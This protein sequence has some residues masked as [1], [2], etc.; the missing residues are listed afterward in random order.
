MPGKT[1]T[2]SE[3]Q[4]HAIARYDMTFKDL[5]GDLPVD[6][7]TF[8][9]SVYY[10]M[11]LDDLYHLLIHLR[12]QN[13][14]VIS[15]HDNWYIPI[16]NLKNFFML[17]P[18]DYERTDD[19]L[20]WFDADYPGLRVSDSSYFNDVWHELENACAFYDDSSHI[21]EYIQFDYWIPALEQYF[22]NKGKP[23]TDWDFPEEDKVSFIRQFSGSFLEEATDEALKLGR[24]FTDEL[25]SQNNPVALRLKGFACYAGD[26]LYPE[27]QELSY[28]CF[29]K[30]FDQN[31]DPSVT[32]NLGN[33]CC[34]PTF[35]HN[36]P[37]YN[38]AFSWYS[39]AAVSGDPNGLCKLGDML[40]SGNGCIRSQKA[41]VSAYKKSYYRT[42][43]DFMCGK[44]YAFADAAFRIAKVYEE[45]ITV[46]QDIQAAY[47]YCLEASYASDLR[48]VDYDY[49]EYDAIDEMIHNKLKELSAKLPS[50]YFK[51]YVD[52]PDPRFL[53]NLSSD[54][55]HPCTLTYERK[56]GRWILTG[57][58]PKP[59]LL[60]DL[61]SILI[62][63]P[64]IS[65][66]RLVK[67]I[68]A[69]LSPDAEINF[70]NHQTSVLYNNYH[71]DEKN[72]T[73]QFCL[74]DQI[75]AYVKTNRFRFYEDRKQRIKF[76]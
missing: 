58:I 40:L 53:Y 34:N 20:P 46:K 27:N 1:I 67:K 8:T 4:M 70:L 69:E 23:I 49:S 41:A 17:N 38:Q 51:D 16:M 21:S 52:Y 7:C 54:S 9:C 24:K 66:C 12:D 19:S 2:L 39:I 59:R 3:K 29:R 44:T 11:T 31:E 13:P 32:Y 60:A 62:T 6:G 72:F 18:D 68:S 43:Y 76:S 57:E 50:D 28:S 64:A 47:Y 71:Y 22:S 5:T 45:G 61:S 73:Y 75:T 25:C 36:G 74:D 63:E 33:I 55:G 35:H 48:T 56:N 37:D 15:F 10:S 14:L 42:R 30:L 26:R 65:F